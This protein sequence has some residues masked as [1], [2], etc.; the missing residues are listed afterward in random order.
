MLT[1]KSTLVLIMAL[2]AIALTTLVG[3][4][5]KDGPN[6]FRTFERHNSNF[7]F[8]M[9]LIGSH[10]PCDTKSDNRIHGYYINTDGTNCKLNTLMYKRSYGILVNYDTNDETKYYINCNN[11]EYSSTTNRVWKTLDHISKNK[12]ICIE[13]SGSEVKLTVFFQKSNGDHAPKH[14]FIFWA[15]SDR[16]N[17]ELDQSIWLESLN[18]LRISD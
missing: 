12:K 6:R 5:T 11:I 4:R 9:T 2:C 15:Q 1:M 10:A 17:V 13:V 18:S 7:R 3:D 14:N 8:D 16:R